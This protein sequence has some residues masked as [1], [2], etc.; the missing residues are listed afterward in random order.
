MADLF[1]TL[2]STA[3]ALDAHRYGLDVVGQNLANVN[4]PGYTRRSVVLEEV[5]PLDPY[6]P[7]GGVDVKTVTASR[8][9]LLDSRLFYERPSAGR[10]SAVAEQLAA[11]EALLAQPGASLDAQLS[12]FYDAFAELAGEPTSSV[13]RQLVVTE[14][15]TLAGGFQRMAQGLV[16]VQRDVDAEARAAIDQINE[17]ARQIAALNAQIGDAFG[18]ADAL[19]DQRTEAIKELSNLVD[20]QVIARDDSLVDLTIGNGRA[21]VTGNLH[22]ALTTT[23]TPP[24]G[25]A[26][27]VSHGA[28]VTAEITGGGLGGLLLTRDVLVPG[29]AQR[30]DD[31]AYRVVTDVNTLHQAG[32]DLLGAAGGAFFEPSAA[33]GAAAAMAVTAAVAADPR[34]VAAASSTAAGDNR[35][36]RAIAALREANPSAI[37]DWGALVFRVG[38]ERQAALREVSSRSDVVNQIE[39]MRAQISGVSLDEE[40]AMLMRFQRAYEANARFFSVIDELLDVLMARVV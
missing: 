27:V 10:E 24:L 14:G 37:D 6:S 17:L 31:L 28:D 2:S 33:A 18:Q 11:V 7:G 20:V 29:Y 35:T 8:T 13:N 3:R 1:S 32:Y 40:A 25:A 5:R 9:P 30:L 15:Q 26:A 12:R 23:S 16:R 19:R 21:L 39:S 4:T 38:A 36:A 22:Y 34:L